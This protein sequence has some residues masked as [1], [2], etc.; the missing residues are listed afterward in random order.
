MEGEADFTL[1]EVVENL[2]LRPLG[3]GGWGRP[4][5]GADEAAPGTPVGVY[6]LL[7]PDAPSDWRAVEAEELWTVY[8]GATLEVELATEAGVRREA[9]HAGSGRWLSILPGGWL[10]TRSVGGW[11]LAG[12]IGLNIR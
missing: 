7:T 10:R 5:A 4:M 12:R 11:C 1:A 8:M 9:L 2:G 6:R 3:E